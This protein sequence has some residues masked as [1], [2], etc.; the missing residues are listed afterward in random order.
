MLNQLVISGF[1][2]TGKSY[3]ISRGEG[4][5]YM[6]QGFASDSDSSKFDKED[7]PQNYIQHVKA[8]LAKGTRRI[9]IS[10]HK[11]VREAL[12]KEGLAFVLVYPKKSLKQEYLERYKQRG[13]PDSFITLISENWDTWLSELE[14]QKG[15]THKQ[16]GSGQFMYDL[17]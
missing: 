12:V 14:E 8:L 9:F 17:F 16:L 6:P 7:F 5:D 2:G 4:S 1:P 3:Y 15:C 11:D 13:S 10:S